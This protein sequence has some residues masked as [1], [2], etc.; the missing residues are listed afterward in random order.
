MGRDLK[1]GTYIVKF[2]GFNPRARMGRD[3]VNVSSNNIKLI[4]SIHAP[5]WG[6][7]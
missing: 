4:V 2:T 5:A 7:T 3:V 6:A 1:P